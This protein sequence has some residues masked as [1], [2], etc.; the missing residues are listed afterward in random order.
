MLRTAG[1]GSEVGRRTLWIAEDSRRSDTPHNARG[2]LEGTTAGVHLRLHGRPRA[3][4][5][6]HLAP[7]VEAERGRPRRVGERRHL[8]LLPVAARSRPGHAPAPGA[9]GREL[10]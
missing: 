9:A 5:T 4:P 1:G 10:A 3:E 8:D 6:D 7:H 2:P